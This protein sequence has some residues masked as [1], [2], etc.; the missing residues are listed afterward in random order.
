MVYILLEVLDTKNV[1]VSPPGEVKERMSAN[2]VVKSQECAPKGHFLP[3]FLFF[4][5]YINHK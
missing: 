1:E 2:P 5:L 4:L 3:V